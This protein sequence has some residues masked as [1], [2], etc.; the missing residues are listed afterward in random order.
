[1]GNRR[2]E[3]YQYRQIIQR[4]RLGESDRAIGRAE[5]V[6]RVKVATL[7]ELAAQR[8]WLDPDGPKPDD[9]S[10]AAGLG[11]PQR[12]PQNLSSVEPFREQLLAWHAQGIQA[13]TR[14]ASIPPY[15]S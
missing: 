9:A 12:P 2:F 8:G 14:L 10:L 5:R 3:T 13:T 1:M 6:G 7:R 4:L 11:A 15:V